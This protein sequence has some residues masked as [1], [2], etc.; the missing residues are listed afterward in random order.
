MQIAIR[1]IV[2]QWQFVQSWSPSNRADNARPDRCWI[3]VRRIAVCRIAVES[4]SARPRF[5]ELRSDCI[6]T[7]HTRIAIGSRL[8]RCPADH[9]WIVIGSHLNC[10]WADSGWIGVQAVVI[11]SLSGRSRLDCFCQGQSQSVVDRNAVRSP[12]DGLWSDRCQEECRCADRVW[13]VIGRVAAE[14]RFTG[15]W[16]G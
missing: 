10:S 6:P 8:D 13:R 9:D 1:P 3:A 14:S 7:D 16:L 5:S 11:R 12:S 2:L 4:W 15:S